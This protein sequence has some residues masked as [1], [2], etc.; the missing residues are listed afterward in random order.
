MKEVNIMR[1]QEW[2]KGRE[3][4]IMKEMRG[5]DNGIE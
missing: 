2:G 5:E 4:R 1:E 3:K